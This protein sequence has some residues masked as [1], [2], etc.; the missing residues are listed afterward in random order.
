MI[1]ARDLAAGGTPERNLANLGKVNFQVRNWPGID[2]QEWCRLTIDSCVLTSGIEDLF[3]DGDDDSGGEDDGY[4]RIDVLVRRDDL[5]RQFR[6]LLAAIADHPCLPSEYLDSG[7]KLDDEEWGQ[8]D[9]SFETEWEDGVAAGRYGGGDFA[10][11]DFIARKWA[12]AVIRPDRV[13]FVESYR[14]MLRTLKIPD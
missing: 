14:S 1:F 8:I 7:P 2:G 13:A 9:Q 5:V 6:D 10:Y 4:R 3:N 12:E 11:L